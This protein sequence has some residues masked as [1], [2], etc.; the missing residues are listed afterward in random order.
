MQSAVEFQEIPEDDA[1]TYRA[2][3]SFPLLYNPSDATAATCL[4]AGW[5]HQ[6]G[7][8]ANP[9]LGA[10]G[11]SSLRHLFIRRNCPRQRVRRHAMGRFDVRA[12]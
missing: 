9:Q 3:W 4:R 2:R 8:Q 7:L 5:K 6:C 11:N 12:I 10:Y 1:V